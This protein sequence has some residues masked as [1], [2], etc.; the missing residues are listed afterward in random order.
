MA[1]VA[2]RFEVPR[3]RE[4]LSFSHHAELAGLP[5]EEQDLWLDRAEA[6]ALSVRSSRSELLHARRRAALAEARRHTVEAVTAVRPK[7]GG[8]GGEL[9]PPKL[10]DSRADARRT[11]A[12]AG[13][14]GGMSTG[15][16]ADAFELVCPEYGCRFAT[17]ANRQVAHPRDLGNDSAA[18]R[19][20]LA[21]APPG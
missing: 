21:P 20:E 8:F 11:V 17:T 15:A 9:E 2:G 18:P 5:A 13:L 16:S 6:S 12:G 19:A 4:A 7:G 10:A 3:R 1:Y 14:Q